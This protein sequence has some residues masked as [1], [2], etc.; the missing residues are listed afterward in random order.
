MGLTAENVASDY[1]LQEEQD[2]FAQSHEKA[3]Q[4]SKADYSKKK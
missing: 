1:K 3:L 4:L 2:E